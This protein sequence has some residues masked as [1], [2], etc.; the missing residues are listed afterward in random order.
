VSQ[1]V[2]FTVLAAAEWEAHRA[3]MALGNAQ[4]RSR[5]EEIKPMGA[6]L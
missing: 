4:A 6:V 2:D 1:A 5:W 3:L